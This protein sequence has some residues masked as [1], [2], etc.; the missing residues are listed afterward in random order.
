[1]NAILGFSEIITREAHGALHARYREYIGDI[2]KSGAHLLT[3]INEVLDFSRLDTGDAKLADDV[4]EISDL[5][6]E[7]TRI[8]GGDVAAA[9]ITLA[10]HIATPIPQVCADRARIRQ[11]LLNLLSNALKFTPAGGSI[12]INASL[13]PDGLAIS[14]TDTGIGIAQE[15]IPKALERFGQ[16]DSRL[17]RKYEGVGLGLPLAKQLIELHDGKLELVSTVAVGTTVTVTIPAARFVTPVQAA[18][19]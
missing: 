16:V 12:Y 6:E 3:L 17:S 8:F 7:V 13:Q 2:S 4:I 1:M 10:V 19:A 11:V 9:E 14:I 5:V 15:D 18:A